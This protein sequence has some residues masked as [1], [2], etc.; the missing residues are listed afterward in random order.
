VALQAN[1]RIVLAGWAGGTRNST[2]AL[3]RYRGG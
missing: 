2:F 3:A 1:G